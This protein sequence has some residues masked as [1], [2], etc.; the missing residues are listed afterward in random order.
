MNKRINICIAGGD[1]WSNRGDRA[2]LS[3]TI[4]LIKKME[5]DSEIS[6]LSGDQQKTKNDFPGL[7]AINRRNIFSLLV[8]VSQS[9]ILLWGGGH[10]LQNTSSKIFLVFQFYIL[11]SAL[12][13][14][15]KVIGF[16]LGVEEIHGSF[17]RKLSKFILDKFQLISVRDI[18][19]KNVLIKLNVKTPIFVTADPAVILRPTT[20]IPSELRKLVS[21]PFV[22]IAPRKWFYYKSSLFPVSWQKKFFHKD[23][24]KFLT[25]LTNFAKLA[26]WIIETLHYNVF[27]IPMYP[28]IEQGDEE[29]SEKIISYMHHRE[30]ACIIYKE[31]EPSELIAFFQHTKFLIGMR[32]H[33]TIL[34]ACSG[35]PIIGL[36]YQEKGKSFFSAMKLSDFALPIEEFTPEN[37]IQL[38]QTLTRN[39][40][41]IKS[42][43]VTNLEILRSQA[44]FNIELLNKVLR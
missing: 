41:K 13:L 15:K 25:V 39:S 31:Y 9:D 16:A 21:K 8:T 28:G 32:M 22:I 3:G 24:V 12:I 23:K 33:A 36:Y 11:M 7:N 40:E 6:I 10:L 26:D 19:S 18:H 1:S 17:W 4:D 14:R 43:L 20:N 2:I 30:S 35:T 34:A 42:T 5:Y 38:I 27:F 44:E 29:V 37:V